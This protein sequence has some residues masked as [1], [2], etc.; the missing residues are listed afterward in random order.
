MRSSGSIAALKPH[1]AAPVSADEPV[2]AVYRGRVRHRRF[3]PTEH[4]FEY[5]LY[6]LYLDLEEIESA[7]ASPWL[8]SHE[9]FNLMSF[10]RRDYL[11]DPTKPLR[12]EVLDAL[13]AETGLRP[14]GSIRML[15]Q[16][17]CLGYVFN[18]VTFYYCFDRQ[19][20]QPEQRL[21]AILVEITNTPWKQRH[22]YAVVADREA[23][24]HHRLDREF[25]KDF[26]ISPFFSMNQRYRWRFSPPDDR[27]VVHMENHEQGHRVFDATLSLQRRPWSK[28]ELARSILRHPFMTSKVTLGIYF[29]ALRLKLKRCPFHPHPD[30]SS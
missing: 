23:P 27:L 1:Q 20:D 14:R 2:S 26:H 10:R 6:M 28:R 4:A 15:T 13:E 11:G 12:T 5:Q 30:H 16:V 29:Q 17:R 7:F 18:P 22:R 25:D 24:T 3:A 21:A 8:W 9:R 19:P